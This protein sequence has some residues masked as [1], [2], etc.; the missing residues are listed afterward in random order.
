M[1]ENKNMQDILRQMSQ[2]LKL[3]ENE[4]KTAAQSGNAQDILKNADSKTQQKVEKIL[5][6]PQK[7]KELL[8]SPQAKAIIEMLRKGK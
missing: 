2:Q 3:S 8:E 7:T 5:S 1:A 4:L 6:D